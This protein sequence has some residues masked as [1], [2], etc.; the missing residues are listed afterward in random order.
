LIQGLI[1]AHRGRRLRAW[2]SILALM[3]TIEKRTLGE[4][5]E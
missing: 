5:Q 4:R 3:I 2:M 1:E